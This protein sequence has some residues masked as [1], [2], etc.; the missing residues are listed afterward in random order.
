V[1]LLGVDACLSR[2]IFRG[3]RSPYRSPVIT[4]FYMRKKQKQAEQKKRI[5]EANARHDKEHGLNPARVIFATH[6]KGRKDISQK[7]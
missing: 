5:A 1:G 6:V 2:K 3:V 4:E 7:R